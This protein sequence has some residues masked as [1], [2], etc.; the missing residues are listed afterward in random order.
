MRAWLAGIET[1]RRRC[2]A[3]ALQCGGDFLDGVLVVC[4]GFAS[5]EPRPSPKRRCVERAQDHGGAASRGTMHA[6]YR[7]SV[8]S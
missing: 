7:L 4:E 8:V 6:R 1:D 5:V 2:E 3:I